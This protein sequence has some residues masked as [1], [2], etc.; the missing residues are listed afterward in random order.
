MRSAVVL[1]VAE[2]YGAVRQK[3]SLVWRAELNR[4]PMNGECLGLSYR[5]CRDRAG[6]SRVR[7]GKRASRARREG[8]CRARIHGLRVCVLPQ[9]SGR[10]CSERF[11]MESQIQRKTGRGN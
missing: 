1:E 2:I 7:G 11:G 10:P 9:T 3:D 6:S 4:V 5:P 8:N